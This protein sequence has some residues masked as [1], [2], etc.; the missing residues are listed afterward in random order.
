MHA[1]EERLGRNESLFRSVNE[2]IEQAAAASPGDDHV[3]EFF[4]E[5]SDLDCTRLLPMTIS[6][7]ESV[8]RS[9]VLFIVA[10][11]HELPDIETVV[12]R[13]GAYHVVTKRG[14]AAEVAKEDDP[15]GD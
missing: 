1:R 10:P 14:E 6:E 9:P 12:S 4:C 15:R 2:R 3:F 7:Y 8:R 13:K 5:C 11:G